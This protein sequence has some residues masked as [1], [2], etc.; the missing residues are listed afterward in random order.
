MGEYFNEERNALADIRDLP[1][2]KLA[3]RKVLTD[4]ADT[5]VALFEFEP[6]DNTGWHKHEFNYC[7]VYLTDAKL[8]HTRRDGS[9]LDTEHKAHEFKA[10]PVGTE[11]NVRNVGTSTVRLLEIEFKR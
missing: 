3:G 4:D 2:G 11:H 7:A 9:E 10:H 6:G 1:V 5:R 8:F